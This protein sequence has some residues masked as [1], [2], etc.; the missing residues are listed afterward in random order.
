M[1]QLYHK[2]C[3][4]LMETSELSDEENQKLFDK[5]KYGNLASEHEMYQLLRYQIEKAYG[6]DLMES[7]EK[8]HFRHERLWYIIYKSEDVMRKFRFVR[9]ML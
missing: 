6:K 7:Y 3:D 5:Q 9:W 2:E 8:G 1:V 4:K